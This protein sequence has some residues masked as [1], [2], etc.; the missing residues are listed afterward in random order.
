MR[1]CVL[2]AFGTE[3]PTAGLLASGLSVAPTSAD[4]ATSSTAERTGSTEEAQLWARYRQA[5]AEGG[6]LGVYTG[7]D[8][9][10][11]D[12]YLKNAFAKTVPK[13]K[14]DIVDFSQNHDARGDRQAA[15]HHAVGDVVHPQTLD[16]PEEAARPAPEGRAGHPS[17]RRP[18]GTGDHVA[19]CGTGDSA[20]GLSTLTRPRESPRVAWPQTGAPPQGGSASGRRQAVPEPAAVQRC[21]EARNRVRTDV[22]PRANRKGIFHHA[23]MNPLGRD[24]FMSDRAALDRYEARLSPYLGDAHGAHSSDPTSSASTR[25]TGRAPK[26][27]PQLDTGCPPRA[28]SRRTP[29]R[30]AIPPTITLHPRKH[31]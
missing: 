22:T 13:T 26:A 31:A 9:S 25:S 17:L 18:S 21:A 14:V 30:E 19:D 27:E 16:D 6:R 11:Q 4:A 23:T 28:G 12:D 5:V 29:R 10:G 1:K 3:A 7:G 24:Q 8:R 2:A 15:E 20:S